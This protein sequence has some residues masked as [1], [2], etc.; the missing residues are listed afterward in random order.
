VLCF[1]LFGA[2]SVRKI[3]IAI[4]GA[5]GLIGRKFLEILQERNFP[6][7]DLFL[8]ASKRSHGKKILFNQKE[9]LIKELHEKSFEQ[10]KINIAL[11]SAGSDVSK[12]FA[13]LA[14]RSGCIVIDN[15]SAWR[16]DNAVPLVVPEINPEDIFLHKNIIANPNCSTIQAVLVLKPLHDF[17]K[18]KR[19]VISTYQA[20]SGAGMKGILDLQNGRKNIL[21][22]KFL[23]KIYNNC[24]PHI[25]I[26]DKSGYTKEELKIINETKKIM[27]EN[28]KITSTAVRVPVI[29]CHSESLNI[30]F[31]NKF[32][33]RDIFYVLKHKA[34][35][36]ILL[37]DINNNLYPMAINADCHDEVFVGRV[38]RDFSLDN[39]INLWTVADNIRKGAATNAIQIAEL[40]Y[41]SWEAKHDII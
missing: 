37:D 27:H 2:M 40:I 13:P 3:N 18:I 28:I 35:G 11:F 21:P 31:K 9:Y 19:V 20:V 23:H 30:E 6:I 25:D 36:V 39:A 38:R 4:V 5:S 32:D 15:S 7:G 26:F 16:E 10:N 14:A 29:N 24:I 41:N 8:F 12:K 1:N 17:F 22:E 33:L 34:P